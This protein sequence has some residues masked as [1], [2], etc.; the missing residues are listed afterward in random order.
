MTE[1]NSS[2]H[3]QNRINNIFTGS[4][5]PSP[6]SLKEME[7]MQNRIQELEANLKLQE[8]RAEMA[9]KE[10]SQNKKQMTNIASSS[11]PKVVD[12]T[13]SKQSWLTKFWSRLT[14][15]H[16]SITD[17]RERNSASL[18]ASF[19]I[20]IFLLIFA[21]VIAQMQ[22]IGFMGAL[23]GPI[24][25]AAIPTLAAYI[26][27]RTKSYR[28][29]IFIFSL[30]F[31]GLAYLSIVRQGAQADVSNLVLTYV[32][33]SLIVASA[34]LSSWAVFLLVGLNVALLF[35]ITQIGIVTLTANVGGQ[36]GLITTIGMMLILLTNFR[37]R[38]EQQSLQEIKTVND[39]LQI[40]NEELLV[41]RV[42]LE[43]RV[44]DRTRDLELASEVGRTITA[45]VDNLYQLLSDA[46]EQIRSRF[47]LYYTQ[48]YLTDRAGRTITLRAGTGEVGKQLLQRGHQLLISSDSLN[49]RAA[50]EKHAAI[51]TDT[52]NSRAFLPNPLLPKT[53]SEMSVPLM[54]GDQVIGVLDMQSDKAN[55]LNESNLPAF[56]A[57]AGQ[58]AVAIQ[59]ASLF[60]QANQARAEVVEQA[61]RMS[62]S[63]WDGFLNAVDRSEK[64]GYV[65]NQN[66]VLPYLNTAETSLELNTL[67]A[68]IQVAGADIGKIQ[69]ADAANRQWTAAEK[70]LIDNTAQQLANH[71]ENLRLLTQSEKYRLDA[72]QISKRLTRESWNDYF[73]LRKNASTGFV[74]NKNKVEPI[75]EQNNGSKKSVET[76]PIYV[77]DEQIGE[78]EI[79]STANVNGDTAEIISAI[80]QQLSNHIENL[81]LLEQAELS[82][83][84]VQK[85]QEQY[86]LAV[87]GSNDGLWDWNITTNQVYFSPRWKEMVGYNENELTEG[88]ADFEKLLHPDDHD[89]VLG[90][91]NDY[92]MG[93]ID[94]YNIEFRFHHKQG[95]Y[96]W[97]LARGKAMRNADG[98]PYR[99][100]GSHT[101]I[102]GR[103]ESEEA[104]RQAQ[105]QYSL[106][107]A[108]SNDGIWD[109]DIANDSI[110]YSPR[111]KG[112]LGY[113]EHELT[114][115]FVEWEELVHPEDRDF[116]TSSLEKYLANEAPEYDVEVRLKHKNGHYVWIRD[117][118]KALRRPD[119]TPY[120]MSGAHT[121]ITQRKLDEQ[122]IAE[123]ANQLETVAT[124]STTASTVLN[125]DAL[126]SQVVNLTKT[127]FNLYHAHI[128]LLDEN[129]NTLLLA[130]GAGEVGSQ[131]V[132]SG[133]AID[134]NA[135]RSLVARAA[136]EKKPVIINDV[137]S[138]VGFL[139]NPLL[140]ETRAE[141]AI[142]MLV[143]DNVLGVFDV[144]SDKTDAFSK[145]DASIYSTL[146][147]QVAVALQNARLY[148]EQS[149]TVTQLRELDR[150]KSSFLANMSHELRTPLN[151]ILGF[152]EVMLEGLDGPLTPNM[153]NDLKLINKN[154][155]HLLLLIND[156]LDMAKI[157]SGKMNLIIE[158]FSVQEIFE[159]VINITSP[160]A[161]EKKLT[162]KVDTKSDTDVE[163]NA[164]RTRIRQ[165]MINLV[166]NALKFTEKGKIIIRAVR[167]E[168]NV[169]IS[170][171]DSG[172]GIPPEHLEAVF[173]EFTQVDSSTTRKAGGTG[174]GLPISRKLIEMHGGKLWAESNG[175]EGEGSTF[176]VFMPLENRTAI[177]EPVTRKI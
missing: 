160:L 77:R 99:M 13:P 33:L 7:A 170:I 49:G 114:R 17:T 144:Q 37:K 96:V 150:L 164:D 79:E 52:S 9:E 67:N 10:A 105:E 66:E 6:A 72:E 54:I 121:D 102:S 93:K 86:E 146:A 71:I 103:K 132:E 111:W 64:I 92:L 90:T 20:V 68:P 130:S 74:Y 78:L 143:G 41:S 43:Q 48:V 80:T 82:R 153:D 21:G 11:T 109:W 61:K 5:V 128:Y 59:N 140:P 38:T 12:S 32:P 1:K 87:T 23:R 30:T 104:I 88:F 136:R 142:P 94:E 57:L 16:A 131:M 127:R 8:Q 155:Q 137:L 28:A 24:M 168:S 42:Q 53:R 163:V 122:L 26:F 3:M 152:T 124:V 39:E 106:A 154:G 126:L 101:D 18:A 35:L 119:G 113:E 81:R 31:G 62:L 171:K 112:M 173:S 138:E 63:S 175:V 129:W 69:I 19:L 85:S 118:G 58:L 89:R 167:E 60:E 15:A 176:F 161:N 25:F 135:E 76:H 29:G 56:E 145:E 169:L 65:Y 151:S 98:T 2:D 125:P 4:D 158:K 147:S 84:E 116:A 115:G 149:A 14:S 133:H 172:I 83:V 162:L 157:E 166:T 36:A 165:V 45:K 134:Y 27:S 40:A 174:L 141:M 91:V 110:Y 75:S 34:F 159:E 47:N 123:R 107:V 97:I 120:R 51:V 73:D 100:A 108:G 50:L 70:E 177:S 22:N 156:V 46:V 55:A 148:Q 139:P 44:Q 117:R 95:H